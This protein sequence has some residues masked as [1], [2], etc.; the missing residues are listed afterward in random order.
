MAGLQYYFFPTDFY[1][2]RPKPVAGTNAADGNV[3]VD[4]NPRV[5]PSSRD[6]NP[7]NKTEEEA[8]AEVA[9]AATVD[10]DM[11][12]ES[13]KPLG[14]LPSKALALSPHQIGEVRR[15]LEA[16][17]VDSRNKSDRNL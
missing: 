1:Y 17:V 7:D 10:S 16:V 15:R 14:N 5:V 6:D 3:N 2:P 11:K 8:A 12:G 13:K 4:V 9:A